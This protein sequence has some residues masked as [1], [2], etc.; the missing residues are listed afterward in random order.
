MPRSQPLPNKPPIRLQLRRRK[1]LPA[2]LQQPP[3]HL[4][5][6]LPDLPSQ[7]L[8]RQHPI[9]QAH[10]HALIQ[11][12]QSQP[13]GISQLLPHKNTQPFPKSDLIPHQ[14]PMYVALKPQRMSKRPRRQRRVSQLLQRQLISSTHSAPPEVRPVRWS[15]AGKG[16]A[17]W[18]ASRSGHGPLPS[19]AQARA[20]KLTGCLALVRMLGMAERHR[21][22][23]FL[24]VVGDADALQ[25]VF[26]RVVILTNHD[27]RAVLG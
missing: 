5:R 25:I 9:E 23:P 24:P 2:D 26:D 1:H 13:I 12:P 14:P 15:G 10:I 20:P 4:Q 19:E 16:A 17:A 21:H 22:D 11:E 6:G 18:R 27:L 7:Q 8:R 3:T